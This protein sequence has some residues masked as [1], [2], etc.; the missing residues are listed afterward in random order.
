MGGFRISIYIFAFI[1]LYEYKIK[2]FIFI[3]GL[4]SC[5]AE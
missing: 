5:K 1:G 2:Y 3:E 4:S